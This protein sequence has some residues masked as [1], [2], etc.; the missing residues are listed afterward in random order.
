[1]PKLDVETRQKTSKLKAL[2]SPGLGIRWTIGDVSEHGFVAL[3]LSILGAF[4]LFGPAAAYR[5]YVNSI[6]LDRARRLT[7]EVPKEVEWRDSGSQLPAFLRERLDHQMAEGVAWKFSPLQAFPERFELALDNDCIL[8]ELPAGLREWLADPQQKR[9][10]IAA[11]VKPCF[12]R[13]AHLAGNKP[14]NSGIRGVPPSFDLEASLRRILRE[15]P[16]DLDSELDEQGLQVAAVSSEREPLVVQVDEVSICSPFPPHLAGL[17]S[18]G[19][20]FVGLNAKSLG[21]KYYDRPGEELLREHF[22]GHLPKV[23]EAVEKG[24]RNGLER[25]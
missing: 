8:W 11:D 12:G 1:M 14:R 4:R 19:V 23:Q 24:A 18:C 15:F 3:R 21:W 13:F 5:V 10:L 20:H 17:G 16:E 6:P 9:C 25:R 2:A 22:F 7:G